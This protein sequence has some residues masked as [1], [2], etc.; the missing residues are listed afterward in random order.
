MIS[1]KTIAPK[2]VLAILFCVFV[3]G[4]GQV[5]CIESEREALL[6]FKNGLIDERGVLSWQSDE[7]CEWNGVECSNTTSHVIAL[8]LNYL[9]L[10]GKVSATLLELHHLNFLDLSWIDFGGIPIPEFIGSMNQLQDLYLSRCKFSG[11]VPPQLG[12]LTNLRSLV[13]SFNSLSYVPLSILDSMWESLELLNLSYNQLNGSLPDL[14]AFSSLTQLYLRDNNFTGSIPQSVGKLSKLRALDLSYNSLTGLVPPSIGQLSELQDL[15]LSHNSLEGLVSESNFIKLDK[16][17]TL[18]LSFNSLIL[19]IPLDWSPPFRLETI[20]LVRCNVG[21]SFPKWIQTQRN[22]SSLDLSGANITDEAPSWLWSFS[23]SL[24]ELYV[25]DNQISGTFPNLSSSSIEYMDLSYNQFSGPIPLFPANAN[26]IH[27]SGNMFSGSISSICKTNYDQLNALDISSNQLEGEVPECW[28][29]MPNL[30][31]LNLANNNFSGE[32][33]GSLGELDLL[34]LQLHGNNLSGELPYNLRLCQNLSIIDVGGNKL[35]GEIPTWIGQLYNMQFLNF[36]GNN[37]HGS[38]PPEICNL[39]KIQVLDL[40]INNLSSIIP[41]CFNN[42]TFLASKD[43]TNILPVLFGVMHLLLK[44]RNH[45]EYSSFQ[46]KGKEFEYSENLG[47]LKLVDFSSNRLTGNIPKSFSMMRGLRSLNLSRN[48]LTGDIIPDIGK[49]ETLD[50]LDLSHN[51][52]SGKIPTS[53]VE[54][55]NLGVLDLSSNNLSG[56]IP[57]STQLQSFTTSTYAENDG[58]CGDPLPMCPGDS[59][60]PPTTNRSENVD[61]KDGN[62]F[63]FMEE[64]GISIGFG[65]IFGFWGVIASFIVKKSWRIAFFN[66]FD[67]AGDWLYVRIAVF[68]FKWRRS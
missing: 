14:R 12:N 4:D 59:L 30:Y 17:K 39:T 68:V 34:A 9:H 62:T 25:S 11:T 21:P 66:L 37:L 55:H 33:P 40:S 52:L 65:F 8:Q 61:E 26:R 24:I 32:I 18:D 41:D 67:D 64:V 20:S 29:K 36:R 7:C 56:K 48:S 15:Y 16:L 35:T 45:Y 27:L 31:S 38:I 57:T 22:L 42:F 60:R 58:L 53:L 47:R 23:S 1:D 28:E 10:R 54:V 43:T 51:Q 44:N 50:S 5:R 6:S 63:S 19:D 46:W 3:S 13:L 49:M 2:F